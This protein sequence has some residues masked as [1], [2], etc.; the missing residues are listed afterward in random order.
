MVLMKIKFDV[1]ICML[2]KKMFFIIMYVIVVMYS[3]LKNICIVKLVYVYFF[4]MYY[5]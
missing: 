1:D 3:I 5:K 4:V 2:N